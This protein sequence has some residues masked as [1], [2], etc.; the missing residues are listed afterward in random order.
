[1]ASEYYIVKPKTKQVFYLGKRITALEGLYGKQPHYPAWEYWEDVLTDIQENSN[2]FLEGCRNNTIG[3]IWDFCYQIYE[4][5]DSEVYL[6]NDCSDTYSIWKDWEVIDV[7]DKIF[8]NSQDELEK[9]SEL[10]LLVPEEQW[11]VEDKVINELETVRQ[12]IVN[13][14]GGKND[15]R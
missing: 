11:V 9:W 15:R 1:M 13:H 2:Y 7:F 5:C 8:T 14:N 3:Q 4:F 12:F 10:F 6:D